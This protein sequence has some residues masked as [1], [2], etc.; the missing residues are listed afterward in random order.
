ML[1]ALDIALDFPFGP[2]AKNRRAV[3]LF[4]DEPAEEGN[5]QGKSLVKISALINKIQTLRIQL[6]MVTPESR[7]YEELSDVD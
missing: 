5:D 1:L 6:F 4:T 3:A 7:G 2:L